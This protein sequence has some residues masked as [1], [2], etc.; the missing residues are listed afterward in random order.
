M[1]RV[2]ISI[3]SNIE[4]YRHV[5]AALD[6]LEAWFGE[7]VISPVYESESVGFEGSDFLNLVVGID[8]DLAVG[9]LSRRFKQLEA[10]N[11]RMRSAPKFSPRTLDLDIL[12]FDQIAG[13]VDGVELPRAEILS[14]AFVLLP[15]ADIAGDELHPVCRQSY[16]QLWH[17]YERDQKL[18]PV[19]FN[20]QG[21]K[22]SRSVG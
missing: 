7:L 3:G 13:I 5:T 6:A 1:S 9:E 10:D 21:R 11:G 22:I 8:T 12:T 4:R 20:W 18:W 15:L 19:D 17:S 14:N 2:Y 16:H